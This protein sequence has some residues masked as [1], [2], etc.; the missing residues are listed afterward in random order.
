MFFMTLK[1]SLGWSICSDGLHGWAQ[2][3]VFE[4]SSLFKSPINIQAA[5]DSDVNIEG[6]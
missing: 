2:F 5:A 3:A 1:P 4:L 6:G